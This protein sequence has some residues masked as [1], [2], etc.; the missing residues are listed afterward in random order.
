MPCQWRPPHPSSLLIPSHQENML[1]DMTEMKA[2][3]SRITKNKKEELLLNIITRNKSDE[4][5]AK[6]V[7]FAMLSHHE[8]TC[9]LCQLELKLYTQ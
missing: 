8:D 5:F 2:I 9:K 3:P 1:Y 4:P 6:H 7:K